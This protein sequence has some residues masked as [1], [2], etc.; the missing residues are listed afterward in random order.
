M[1]GSIPR[2]ALRHAQVKFV[3]NLIEEG[4]LAETQLQILKQVDISPL[5][6]HSLSVCNLH[7]RTRNK[8]LPLP[9]DIRLN[10][11]PRGI[12]HILVVQN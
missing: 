6:F 8:L 2:Y 9:F 4:F 7:R 1:N 10:V 12:V 3:S 11:Q 5:L